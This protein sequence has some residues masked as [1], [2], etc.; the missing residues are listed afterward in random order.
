MNVLQYFDGIEEANEY[1][2]HE[3]DS[4]ADLRFNNSDNSLLKMIHLNIRSIGKNFDELVVLLEGLNQRF[5]LIILTETRNIEDLDLYSIPGYTNF[6][7]EGR[8]NSNDGVVVFVRE[9]IK[10][11]FIKTTYTENTFVSFDFEVDSY[12]FSVVAVYR[13][14][15]TIVLQFIE[16]LDILVSQ[17]DNNRICIFTGDININIL[18]LNDNIANRY[19]NILAKNGF[20]S[21][22]NK[23]TRVTTTSKTAIDHVFVRKP[24]RHCL[25][26][27]PT[28]LQCDITDHYAVLLQICSDNS[29]RVT[30]DTHPHS[31]KYKINYNKLRDLMSSVD[32]RKIYVLTD[33]NSAYNDFIIQF[34]NIIN[35][36]KESLRIKST[37]KKIKPWITSGLIQSIRN[38]DKLK[39]D[40]LKRKDD[41]VKFQQYKTYRNKLNSLLR[42]TKAQY[43]YNKLNEYKTDAKKT[44]RLI[45]EGLDK[46][47]QKKKIC[48]NIN[49]K[50]IESETDIA[51]AFNSHFVNVG[52]DMT[53]NISSNFLI[54]DRQFDYP[55]LFITPITEEEVLKNIQKLKNFAAPGEDLIT[56]KIIKEVQNFICTPLAFIYNLSIEQGIFPDALKNAIVTPVFKSGSR[57]DL[58]NYR[59]ISVTNNFS[60]IFEMSLKCRLSDHLEHNKILSDFQ[61]GF[62]ENV[63]TE[64]AIYQVTKELYNSVDS[65][66]KALAIFLDLAKAFDC[67]SHELL[68]D[69]LYNYGIRGIT[70]DLFRS[71]LSERLQGVKIGDEISTV[72]TVTCGVPQGTVLGPILFLTYINELL[73]LKLNAKVISYAD[74]TVIL[75]RGNSWEEVTDAS[76]QVFATVAQWFHQNLLTINLEK[77]KFMYYAIYDLYLPSFKK[78]YIHTYKCLLN[79]KNKCKCTDFVVFT[80]KY[81]YLGI[82]IDKNLKWCDHIIQLNV[83]LRKLVPYF[84]RLRRIFPLSVLKSVYYALA[85]PLLRYC[86]SVWGG[87]FPSNIGVLNVTQR[88]ILKVMFFKSRFYSS[89]LLFN[90]LQ[91]LN[92]NQLY[93]RSALIFTY[94]HRELRQVPSITYYTRSVAYGKARLPI[95]AKTTTQKFL[96]YYGPKLYNVLPSD[97][98]SINNL[99]LFNKRL[100]QYILKNSNDFINAL[101]FQV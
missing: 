26:L 43:F 75:V 12:L 98:R 88:F 93:I 11:S 68:L 22:I 17:I 16:E 1:Y 96:T 13:L 87:T 18:D 52:R 7:S 59:P 2:T 15:S 61:F 82:I 50:S 9:D 54:A 36:S 56:G 27:T 63:G 20:Y 19:L 77:T 23:A 25:S 21:C 81:K 80:S 79:N 57:G 76:V 83:K 71:Y 32:W 24:F 67:V 51:E 62:R 73:N 37:H 44:W 100:T 53:N 29:S 6:Y 49:G 3:S 42:R 45:N 4:Y 85:E 78:L 14:P 40:F 86:I 38:R 91:I 35:L 39:A 69:R 34:K 5:D 47:T 28:I 101:H 30:I 92:L 48:L 89:E 84:Y 60:K 94:K 90:E 64:D 31:D 70:N 99:K 41:V 58:S 33:P 10:V 66:M 46:H 8:H 55:S 74:D 72:R 97:L 95:L 65:D